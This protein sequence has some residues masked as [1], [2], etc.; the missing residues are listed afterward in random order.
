MK[1]KI[2]SV[3]LLSIAFCA[4][5]KNNNTTCNSN[6]A[7]DSGCMVRVVTP[8]NSHL[9]DSADIPIV[10][11]LFANN[12]IDCSRYRYI[13]YLHDSAAPTYYPPY[14]TYD[15]KVVKTIE[16]INNLAIFNGQINFEFLNG[17]FEFKAGT[18]THGTPLDTIP[19]LTLGQLRKLFINDVKR[20]IHNGVDYN[21]SCL[22]AEFGYFNL[23]ASVS[24]APEQLVKA[25]KVTLKNS[26]YPEALAAYYQDCEG[27]LVGF[28]GEQIN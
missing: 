20:Y 18:A 12:H 19:H 9:I 17:I 2:L 22:K 25:W 16:Y 3:L 14:A 4:C 6:L 11:A 10:N 24:N 1:K 27:Q 8:V 7:E 26:L 13:A 5:K 23:N 15:D 28:A 21:D